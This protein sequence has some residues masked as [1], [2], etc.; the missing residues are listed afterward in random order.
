MLHVLHVLHVQTH[1]LNVLRHDAYLAF[2]ETGI[3]VERKYKSCISAFSTSGRK[4]T[5]NVPKN[6]NL[7]KMYRNRAGERTEPRKKDRTG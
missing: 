6:E 5:E 7:P 4:C 1:S 3:K 2:W